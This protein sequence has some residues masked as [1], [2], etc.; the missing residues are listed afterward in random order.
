[1]KTKNNKWVRR[2][3]GLCALITFATIARAALAQES[4]SAVKSNSSAAAPAVTINPEADRI[5]K[6]TSALLSGA[7]SFSVSA[8]VWEDQVVSGHKVATTKTVDVKLRRPDD[9]QLEVHSP[10]HTRGFWVDGKT[11]TILDRAHNL[12]GTAP[13]AGTID[14]VMDKAQDNF[15]I[16]FPLEDLFVSDPYAAM[17][18]VTG[19]AYFGKATI[20][21]T[22]CQYIA[23]G[24]EKIDVQLWVQDGAEALPRKL[25][26]TYK[27]E[28]TQPQYTAIFSNWK[29]NPKFPESTFAFTPPAGA[30][31]IEMMPAG[32]ELTPTGRT[33][34][35]TNK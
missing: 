18:Q 15:G 1:M 6:Q 26:I 27:Q 35:S 32:A 22:P 10:K 20:L 24:N 2:A 16:T 19:G 9:L 5:F 23:F 11:V 21:G 31:K 3:I 4:S 34:E 33:K 30:S 13:A 14:Q 7:K 29:L 17:A 8:E 28:K 25:V 12:Y